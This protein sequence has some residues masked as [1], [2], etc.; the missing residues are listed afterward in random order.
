MI[1]PIYSSNGVLTNQPTQKDF[2]I[3]KRKAF[4]LVTPGSNHRFPS[5]ERPDWCRGLILTLSVY[6]SDPAGIQVFLDYPNSPISSRLSEQWTASATQEWIPVNIAPAAANVAG[7]TYRYYYMQT[8]GDGLDAQQYVSVWL[9]RIWR[10][11]V[12]FPSGS[13]F[14]YQL[15]ATYI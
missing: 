11:R 7:Q 4:G 15:A 9:P 13:N 3:Q 2:I 5:Q 6:A 14:E 12:R 1:A 8:T 10:A